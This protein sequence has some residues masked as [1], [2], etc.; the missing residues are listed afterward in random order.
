MTA[1]GS[2]SA[3]MSNLYDVVIVGAGVAG[4][5]L[6][7][8]LGTDGRSVFLVERDLK[9]PGTQHGLLASAYVYRVQIAS[10]ASSCNQEASPS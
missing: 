5:A 6:A 1:L 8:A 4:S 10:L 9:E 3:I 2:R 7:H